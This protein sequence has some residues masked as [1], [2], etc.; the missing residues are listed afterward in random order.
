MNQNIS[1]SIKAMTLDV[2]SATV[3]SVQ[4][5]LK[6]NTDA[7][8]NAT[9]KISDYEKEVIRAMKERLATFERQKDR[10]FAFDNIRTTIFWAGCVGNVCTLV[11]LLYFLFS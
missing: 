3:K 8:N 7:L 1:E 11:L 6:A 9:K 4:E 10:L 2:K 5:A